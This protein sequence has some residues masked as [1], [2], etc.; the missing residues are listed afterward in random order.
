MKKLSLRKMKAAIGDIIMEY[1]YGAQAERDEKEGAFR[2]HLSH[3]AHVEIVDLIVK[4]I[5]AMIKENSK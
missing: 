1:L 2:G 5:D 3:E 4:K